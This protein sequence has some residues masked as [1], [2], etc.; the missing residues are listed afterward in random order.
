M[1][2]VFENPTIERAVVRKQIWLKTIQSAV[3]GMQISEGHA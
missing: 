2:E 1:T 3:G